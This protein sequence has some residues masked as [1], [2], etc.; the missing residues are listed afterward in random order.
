MKRPLFICAAAI[1]L[2]GCGTPLYNGATQA[3]SVADRHPITVDQQTVSLA[4]QI[5]PTSQGLNRGQLADIDAFV[6]AYRIR[7]H[8][9]IT[10]TAPTGTRSDLDG[11]ETAANVRAA[12]NSFGIDYRDLQGSS[13]RAGGTPEAVIVSFVQY[14]ATAPT[15]GDFSGELASRLRNLPPPNYGCADRHNLAAMV[16][17]PRD[18][19]RMQEG[20]LVDGQSAAEKIRTATGR[21]SSVN[22]SGI[23]VPDGVDTSD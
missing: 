4:V 6:T 8:G 3:T 12:L 5:D 17:D 15:C 23:L 7:G 18:L 16:A 20:G 21:E 14:V 19:T 10:V 11:A 1:A 22:V 2:M 9:P 13:Y